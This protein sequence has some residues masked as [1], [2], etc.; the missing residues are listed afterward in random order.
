MKL[1]IIGSGDAFGTGGRFHT[2]FHVSARAQT[3]LIDF[4]A[5]SPVAMNQAGRSL[6]DIDAIFIS[7]LHGDHFGGLPFAVLDASHINKRQRPLTIFG[8]P[9]I[10]A[11]YT[12]LA[13]AM[14]SGMTT[15]ERGFELVFREMHE[16]TPTIWGDATVQ[17]FAVEHPS[18]AP[19]HALRFEL[20]D[21][22]LAFSGDTVWCENVYH[23]GKDA[24]LYL[25]E[26]YA[27]EDL[28]LRYHMNWQTISQNLA[29]L[30]ARQ[31][32]LTHMGRNMLAN[33]HKVTTPGVLIAADQ[34]QLEI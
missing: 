24:D 22:V 10:E 1:T 2:C 5:S 33:A 32:V 26:C 31:I 7:H 34:M 20:E 6:H 18:G 9:T 13:E 16:G 29:R 15:K 8:P 4:G 27:Y 14:F 19:S 28:N 25:M 17:A 11:R 3:F 30:Q 12:A 21:K 23:A